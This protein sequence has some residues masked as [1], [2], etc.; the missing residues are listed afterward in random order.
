MTVMVNNATG[1]GDLWQ[2]EF[3]RWLTGGQQLAMDMPEAGG[4]VAQELVR[5]G[6]GGAG[7]G[8]PRKL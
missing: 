4:H 1:L 5:M 2:M 3:G 8:T 7:G 6:H